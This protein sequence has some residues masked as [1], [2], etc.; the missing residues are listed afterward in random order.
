[1]A[2]AVERRLAEF[3][4]VRGSA[5]VSPRPAKP[6]G[7]AAAPEPAGEQ[8]AAAAGPGGGAQVSAEVGGAGPCGGGLVLDATS[9]CCLRRPVLAGR[10]W[11]LRCGRVRC[12]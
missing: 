11:R 9:R 6:L 3:R 5:A 10:R 12:C 4:A 7:K 8:Q 1:M 2:A